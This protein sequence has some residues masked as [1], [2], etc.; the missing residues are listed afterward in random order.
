MIFLFSICPNSLFCFSL[1]C[2]CLLHSEHVSEHADAQVLRGS[3][4]NLLPHIRT[5]IGE[6][7]S[8]TEFLLRGLRFVSSAPRPP[9]PAL[10]LAAQRGKFKPRVGFE[11]HGVNQQQR[12][13]LS[14][15]WKV[16]SGPTWPPF[17]SSLSLRESCTFTIW[18]VHGAV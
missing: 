17:A 18:P 3:D 12:Q 7:H 14:R 16:L 8:V 4:G 5:H 6:L 13:E 2:P 15:R 11:S 9:H 10:T 1:F